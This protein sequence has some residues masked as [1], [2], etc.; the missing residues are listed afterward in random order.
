MK[1]VSEVE[2]PHFKFCYM[3]SLKLGGKI[4][5]LWDVYDNSFNKTGRTHERGKPLAE[6][7]NHLVVHIYPMN[8]KGELLIQKRQM[9]LS[10]KPG[11]WSGTGGSA[12]LGEDAWAACQR[13]LEEELGIIATRENTSLAFLYKL[14]DHFN[15]V[16]IVKTDIGISELKLQAEEVLDAKWASR[17][18]I[19]RMTEE[20]TFIPYRYMNSLF[21]F[22]KKEFGTI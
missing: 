9:K 6:G 7:D 13:E 10:W 21:E 3:F 12:I 20:G 16:W 1:L 22:I 14:E 19:I 4:M 2:Q 8:S 15:S 11:F 5:E 18:E 17:D